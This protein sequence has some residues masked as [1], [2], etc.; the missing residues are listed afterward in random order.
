MDEAKTLVHMSVQAILAAMLLAAATGLISLGYLMWSYF[1][2]QDAANQRMATYANYTAYDNTTIRGQEVIELLE[3]DLDVFVLIY[4][5]INSVENHSIDDATT[6]TSKLLA[7]HTGSDGHVT[8]FP[9][10]D[11]DT[12]NV[13]S[14]CKSALEAAKGTN[15]TPND[16]ARANSSKVLPLGYNDLVKEFTQSTNSAYNL[17]AQ[18]RS[19]QTGQLIETGSYAAFKSALVYDNDNTT[20]VVG[21]ILIRANDK[22]KVTND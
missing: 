2:R 19:P 8:N 5:D 21:I 20:D 18:R 17:G 15:Q 14:A 12:E 9:L 4:E 16:L 7:I 13:N 3:S 1:S 22:C 10:K 11:I 6:S